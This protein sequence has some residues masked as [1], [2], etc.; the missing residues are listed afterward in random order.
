MEND[1]SK[2]NSASIRFF[3]GFPIPLAIRQLCLRGDR[4]PYHYFTWQG[5]DGSCVDSF[6]P[7]DYTYR[8]DPKQICDVW[9]NRVQKRGL[10]AFLLPFGYG[11]GGGGPTRDY[12]EFLRREENLEGM[13]KVKT[14][15]PLRFFEDMEAAGGPQHTYVGELYFSAHRGVFT[16]Q[17]AIKKGNRR[18]EIGLREAEMWGT[19]AG[20][21]GAEYP[22]ARMDAAWKKLLLNQFH[23]I[24]PGSSIGRVY[25]DARRD[26]A[27]IIN[28]A[29]AVKQD[30]L[31]H[32]VQ[33]EGITVFNSLS[34]ARS[35]LVPLP[36]DFAEG[37]VTEDGTEVPVQQT[38]NGLL[39]FVRVPACGA[40]SLK[41][42]TVLKKS[43][44]SAR[45]EGNTVVMENE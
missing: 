15:S 12:L 43:P 45:E 22:L 28:E 9:N 37:A 25:E 42:K 14:E 3:C 30:A 33:G 11:D 34:F 4:F 23:D 19:M 39:G 18:A 5:A 6:L 13:P 44:V 27:W 26:H 17:A 29:E 32:L 2:K 38:D 7:T 10:D 20:L 8:T 21:Q 36:E 31:S 40:V 35:G 1:S 41:P 16:S 24:L